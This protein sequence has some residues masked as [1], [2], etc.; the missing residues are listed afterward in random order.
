MN[1]MAPVDDSQLR[2]LLLRAM[3]QQQSEMRIRSILQE[4]DRLA[5]R[6]C[7]RSEASIHLEVGW[8]VTVMCESRE[9]LGVHSVVL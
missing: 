8:G 2:H 6:N 3:A 7:R 1:R 5:C 4:Y 9:C